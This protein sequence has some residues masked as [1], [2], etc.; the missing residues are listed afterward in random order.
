MS[1]ATRGSLAMLF[2]NLGLPESD[3]PIAVEAFEHDS[4][5]YGRGDWDQVVKSCPLFFIK[6]FF[7]SKQ[8][9]GVRAT[10]WEKDADRVFEALDLP[11]R[12]G[13]SEQEFRNI[14][15]RKKSKENN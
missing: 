9:K 8:A 15:V 5:S 3:I 2:N 10:T 12:C 4:G 1:F 11:I 13:M 7:V 6:I 14:I